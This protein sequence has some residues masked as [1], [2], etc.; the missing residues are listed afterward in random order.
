MSGEKIVQKRKSNSSS[1]WFS[2]TLWKTCT[3]TWSHHCTIPAGGR[4]F[5]A[6]KVHQ[7][8]SF[9][10]WRFSYRAKPHVWFCL[11]IW[12]G[13]CWLPC[14]PGVGTTFSFICHFSSH[15]AIRGFSSMERA[16]RAAMVL[17]SAVMCGHEWWSKCHYCSWLVMHRIPRQ[18]EE[19]SFCYGLRWRSKSSN[20][21]ATGLKHFI[22]AEACCC[23]NCRWGKAKWML[24]YARYV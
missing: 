13:T 14:W 5:E 23:L 20:G 24:G 15:K 19:L 21:V 12:S 17:L 10:G 16:K 8:A 11:I 9:E 3:P 2:R 1:V 18:F 4:R 6:N 22:R 7:K